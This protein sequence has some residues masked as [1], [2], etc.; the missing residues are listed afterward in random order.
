MSGSPLLQG[1]I[2][3]SRY[4][5]AVEAKG[6]LKKS[7]L[8]PRVNIDYVRLIWEDIINKLNKKTREKLSLTL[9]KLVAFKAPKT[10]SKD[11]KK[12]TKGTNPGATS[13]RRKKQI[14]VLYNHPQSKIEA[15]KCV[16]LKRDTGFQT[17][18]SVKE[19][20]SSSAKDTNPSQPPSP[21]PMVVRMHKVVQQETGGP[22]SLGVPVKK[23]STFSSVV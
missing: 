6:T 23:D 10:S 5:E 9:D 21:T 8:P 22:T 3:G 4:G 19:T 13:G 17:G 16:S 7:L 12:V 2:R 11:E 15:A 1:H 20:Q 18:H 14:P